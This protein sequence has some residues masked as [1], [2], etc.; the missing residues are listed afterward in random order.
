MLALLYLT[1]NAT[2]ALGGIFYIY[3]FLIV[4]VLTLVSM[5]FL[6]YCNLIC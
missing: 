4:N 1:Y 2:F 5:V 3:H 6:E